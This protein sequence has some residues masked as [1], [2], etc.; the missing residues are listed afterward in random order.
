VSWHSVRHV[1]RHCQH[2]F[3]LQQSFSIVCGHTSQHHHLFA[4]NMAREPAH[5]IERALLL[6]SSATD[7]E[8]NQVFSPSAETKAHCATCGKQ[9]TTAEMS[10]TNNDLFCDIACYNDST[11]TCYC[12]LK[13][14]KASTFEADFKGTPCDG[15]TQVRRALTSVCQLVAVLV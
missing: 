1:T 13:E 5:E 2:I 10:L 6:A 3:A 12:C 14:G 15:S 7:E 11:Q 4:H 9:G 8:V